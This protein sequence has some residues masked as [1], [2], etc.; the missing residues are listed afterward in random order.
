[1]HACIHENVRVIM[2]K[3]KMKMKN[4]SHRY[5]INKLKSKYKVSQCDDGFMYSAKPKQH[6]KLNP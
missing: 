3:M 4:K 1:M 5:D 2:M 6:L